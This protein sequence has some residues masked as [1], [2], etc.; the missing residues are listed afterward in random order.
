MECVEE[1]EP[2]MTEKEEERHKKMLQEAPHRQ[3]RVEELRR[4]MQ[5]AVL[6]RQVLA[7]RQGAAVLH[8]MALVLELAQVGTREEP[9]VQA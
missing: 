2:H 5:G 3:V 9:E 1:L 7:R 8:R 4:M 6:H